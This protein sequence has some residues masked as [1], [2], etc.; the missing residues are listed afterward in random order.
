MPMVY[1]LIDNGLPEGIDCKNFAVKNATSQRFQD[2]RITMAACRLPDRLPNVD[3]AELRVFAKSLGQRDIANRIDGRLH[4]AGDMRIEPDRRQEPV[5]QTPISG[6]LDQRTYRTQD[7]RVQR[8]CSGLDPRHLRLTNSQLIRQ[9]LLVDPGPS[10][11]F[12]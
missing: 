5:K 6:T 7:I 8:R 3:L 9:A 11:E 12:A 1:L 10:P 2:Q 4:Q